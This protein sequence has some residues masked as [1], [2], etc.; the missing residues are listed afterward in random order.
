MIVGGMA[1]TRAGRCSD[2]YASLSTA[3]SAALTKS[4]PAAL[5]ARA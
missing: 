4:S 2:R 5:A 1:H 3:T